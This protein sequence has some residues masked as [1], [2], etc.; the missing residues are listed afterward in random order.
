MNVS[1]R[2]RYLVLTVLSGIGMYLFLSLPVG[3][4]VLRDCF[5]IGFGGAFF[6][7]GLEILFDRKPHT[8]LM[9]AILPVY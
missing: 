1:K 5:G 6:W 7:F 2:W 8:K 3:L 4:P 9:T